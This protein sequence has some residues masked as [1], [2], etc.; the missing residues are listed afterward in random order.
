[1]INNNVPRTIYMCC[2]D[3]NNIPNKVIENWKKLNPEYKIFLYDDNE[4]IDYLKNNKLYGSDYAEFFEKIPYGPIKADLW[5][6]CILYENGG[7]YSDIDV[8]PYR[9]IDEIIDDSEVTFCSSINMKKNH[10]FQSF[11]YTTPKNII[12]KK[13]INLIMNKKHLLNNPNFNPNNG[14]TDKLYW[15]LS[16]TLDMYCTI[17][18]ILGARNLESKT[19]CWAIGK[20]PIEER[21]LVSMSSIKT[22]FHNQK[23]KLL[24]EYTSTG[25]AKDC[26]VE[27][28][29]KDL[30]A[31]RYKD[32]KMYEHSF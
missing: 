15:K 7:V 2:K 14:R 27:F 28:N 19:Y 3:K 20:F 24:Q 31:S 13:C 23:I 6:L 21:P 22:S 32:Y 1:M 12:I 9:S 4:C 30:F 5:R 8:E 25:L 17:C 26:K 11:I 18:W 29:G 16:G 10:I